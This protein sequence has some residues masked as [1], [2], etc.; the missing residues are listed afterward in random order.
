[1]A[2]SNRPEFLTAPDLNTTA[3]RQA[4]PGCAHKS[5]AYKIDTFIAAARALE[6]DED[7]ARFNE[8]L[9]KV[10]RQKPADI[11]DRQPPEGADA[12]EPS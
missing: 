9:G 10:A 1:M 5:G 8:A 6:C 4:Q 3:A 7:E 11:I 12:S 2:R